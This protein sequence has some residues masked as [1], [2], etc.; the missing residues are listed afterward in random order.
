MNEKSLAVL[1]FP[2]VREQLVSRAAFAVSK[3]L[4]AALRPSA[5]HRIVAAALRETS[6][7]RALLETQPAFGVGGARDIRV[8]VDRAA[9]GARLE[10]PDLLDVLM[11]LQ[12]AQR[13]QS[14]L[15]QLRELAPRLAKRGRSHRAVRRGAGG[16]RAQYRRKRRGVG[17][18][19]RGT[20][21]HSCRGTHGARTAASSG[22]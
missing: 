19:I 6:E 3:E 2:K 1:E 18:G 20:R 21:T 13:V 17:C 14:T 22:Q 7:A 5:D 9:H 11:T 4:A 15:R 12:S 8:V 10:P 16:Y